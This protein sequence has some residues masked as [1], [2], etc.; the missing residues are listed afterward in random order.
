MNIDS[1]LFDSGIIGKKVSNSSCIPSVSQVFFAS[2]SSSCHST[3]LIMR[4]SSRTRV[5]K[6]AILLFPARVF[7]HAGVVDAGAFRVGSRIGHC[8]KLQ[9]GDELIH[10]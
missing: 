10:A 4:A 2:G 1:E 5:V 8:I 9:K 7:I 6:E 3:P